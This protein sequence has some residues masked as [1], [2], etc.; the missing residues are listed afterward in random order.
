MGDGTAEA[1]ARRARRKELAFGWLPRPAPAP[2]GSI[3]GR[4]RRD[5]S[6]FLV[7]VFA[8]NLLF[9]LASDNWGLRALVFLLS[10]LVA[11]LVVLLISK[12]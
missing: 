1:A 5:T 11:P 3:A 10:V 8:V 12:N 2:S 9:V 7:F 6:V 4:R